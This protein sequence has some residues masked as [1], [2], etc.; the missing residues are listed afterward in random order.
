MSGLKRVLPKTRLLMLIG[1][2]RWPGF[3]LLSGFFSKDEIIGG[4]FFAA[5][6]LAVRPRAS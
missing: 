4:V 2:L 3:P 5:D 6:V 1:C